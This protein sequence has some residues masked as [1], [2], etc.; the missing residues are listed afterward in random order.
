MRFS[1]WVAVYSTKILGFFYWRKERVEIRAECFCHT[2]Y[3]SLP[4]ASIN[5]TLSLIDLCASCHGPLWMLKNFML[6]STR[7]CHASTHMCTVLYNDTGFRIT[8]ATPGMPVQEILLWTPPDLSALTQPH[9]SYSPGRLFCEVWDLPQNFIIAIWGPQTDSYISTTIPEE[10][11]KGV[12]RL[13]WH[14]S[15]QSDLL[16]PSFLK[17]VWASHMS[18]LHLDEVRGGHIPQR[19]Y[20]PVFLLHCLPQPCENRSAL[21]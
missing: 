11:L 13:L 10:G 14:T 8:F 20:S 4:K 19:T 1:F 5:S 6:L 12:C 2:C 17:S 15:S 9:F 21:G 3:L 16:F 18:A 7:R